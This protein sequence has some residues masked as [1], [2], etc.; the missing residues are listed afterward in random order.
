M[1]SVV[2]LLVIVSDRISSAYASTGPSAP[3]FV[4]TPSGRGT[5]DLI[6]SCLFTLWPCVWT[7][8][9]LNVPSPSLRE[10]RIGLRR[11][12]C[13]VHATI[14]PEYILSAALS[15]LMDARKIAKLQ[16]SEDAAKLR[17]GALL[18]THH[19]SCP[20]TS[21]HEIKEKWTVE[22]GFFA[23]MGGFALCSK[24]T[25]GIAKSVTSSGAEKLA[26]LGL[27]PD[28]SSKTIRQRS[29]SGQLAK[30]IVCL[31]VFWFF[32]QVIARKVFGLPITLLELNT[33]AHVIC[34]IALYGIW[35]YKP[36]DASEQVI[37][38]ITECTT[39]NELLRASGAFDTDSP[40]FANE[41][42][43]RPAQS[44]NRLEIY[45][46]MAISLVYGG[47]HALAWNAEFPSV[48]EENL[49]RASACTIIFVCFWFGFTARSLIEGTANKIC[50]I[51]SAFLLWL[52]VTAQIF[53]IVEAFISIRALPIGAY[54]TVQWSNAFP[55]I[56]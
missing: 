41:V 38:D 52:Y 48:V 39:C 36:Q 56:G 4:P 34:A 49:W 11:L 19:P 55:H 30:G 51:L 32:M 20:T 8:L 44:W 43:F 12:G 25:E 1:S 7:A 29:K 47:I 13:A 35:W 45:S 42:Y 16:N 5:I 54:D 14:F 10:W 22:H 40:D 3:A 23:V 27:L 21:S 6:T 46:L 31:Q 15:Q 33:I 28:V 17:Q 24:E 50:D 26:Q 9:H 37:I 53:L 2:L 18:N